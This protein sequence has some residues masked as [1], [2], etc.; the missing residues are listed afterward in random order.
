MRVKL[1]VTRNFLTM[2]IPLIVTI[3]VGGWFGN[4]FKRINDGPTLSFEYQEVITGH[5]DKEMS[6]WNRFNAS[7]FSNYD[8]EIIEDLKKQ[9]PGLGSNSTV[10]LSEEERK[11]AEN[12]VKKDSFNT[13]LSDRLPYDRSLPDVRD[14]RCSAVRYDEYL[15]TA[16]VIIIFNNEVFSALLRTIWSVLNRSPKKY[17]KEIILVD[18]FSDHSYLQAKLERCKFQPRF[19]NICVKTVLVQCFRFDF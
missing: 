19:I 8:R 10:V 4:R 16:S 15:P 7:K 5:Q 11:L 2:L 12:L 1:F 17:L 14:Q 18:D 6:T 3:S 9:E 13:L